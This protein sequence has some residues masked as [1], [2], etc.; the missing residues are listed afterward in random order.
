MVDK[1]LSP[2]SF[3][4]NEVFALNSNI[5]YYKFN[6]DLANQ[7]L[8]YEKLLAAKDSLIE[9]DNLK[10]FQESSRNSIFDEKLW[11]Y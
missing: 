6:E 3:W 2:L 4:L 5:K 7:V 9:S 8:Y 1:Y 11:E 10:K